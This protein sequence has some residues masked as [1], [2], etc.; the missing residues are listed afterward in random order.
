MQLESRNLGVDLRRNVV[1]LPLQLGGVLRDVLGA[2]RLVCEAHVH[3][4]GGMTFGAR[5]VDEPALTQ[6]EQP[7]TVAKPVLLHRRP[8]LTH[9][10]RELVQRLQVDL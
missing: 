4:R 6:E 2:Q 5:K 3:H 9:T 8:H 10:G 1:N 7:A